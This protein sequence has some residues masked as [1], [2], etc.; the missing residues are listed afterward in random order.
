M[1]CKIISL[2]NAFA[3]MVIAQG[4]YANAAESPPMKSNERSLNVTNGATFTID[5]RCAA[6]RGFSWQLVESS[7]TNVVTV[8]RQRF[9][10]ET[11][12]DGSDGIQHFDFKASAVGK[13]NLKFIYVQPFRKPFPKDAKS[14]NV[15]VTIK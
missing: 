8:L 4:L 15:V 11:D 13:T 3:L 9:T 5:L 6:G 1:H 14:T 7:D 12:K 10:N 2:F